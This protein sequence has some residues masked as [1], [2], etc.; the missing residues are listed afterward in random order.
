MRHPLFTFLAPSGRG[1]PPQRVGERASPLAEAFPLLFCCFGVGHK[2]PGDQAE[3]RQ[4][5][6]DEHGAGQPAHAAA[7]Q[8]PYSVEPPDAVN[9]PVD[10]ADNGKQKQNLFETRHG[11]TLLCRRVCAEWMA[12]MRSR[13]VGAGHARPA[14]FQYVHAYPYKLEVVYFFFFGFGA[15]SSSYIA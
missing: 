3:R 11:W 4:P 13:T 7:Q 6:D 5:H 15:G 1:L 14:A 10:A 9:A 8:P 2:Q 12:F